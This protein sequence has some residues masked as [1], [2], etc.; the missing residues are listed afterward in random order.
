MSQLLV[1]IIR[2]LP[3]G[4]MIIGSFLMTSCLSERDYPASAGSV[5][6]T[7]KA[8]LA[9]LKGKRIYFGHQSV[10]KNI[11]EG[12]ALLLQESGEVGFEI[13]N[14]DS[15]ESLG[16]SGISH[17]RL[18]ANTEPRGK[19][20]AFAQFLSDSNNCSNSWRENS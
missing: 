15:G 19:C 5:D 12:L 1:K 17:A 4:T 18:G 11:M 8:D 7:F 9:L 13:A 3:V 20:Q 14:R 2:N 6:E 10:G 16:I